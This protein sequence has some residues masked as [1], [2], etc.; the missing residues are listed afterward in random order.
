[1]IIENEIIEVTLKNV[2][3]K[4]VCSLDATLITGHEFVYGTQD[5][6]N[7]TAVKLPKIIENF[8]EIE[9]ITKKDKKYCAYSLY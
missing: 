7:Q 2:E 5:W 6:Q 4:N 9:R 8:L 3:E 1:M